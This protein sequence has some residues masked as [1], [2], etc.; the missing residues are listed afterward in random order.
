MF[1]SNCSI[2][3]SAFKFLFLTNIVNNF[4]VYF[5]FVHVLLGKKIRKLR[6]K[7]KLVLRQVAAQLEIDTP[8][9]SKIERG[10]RPAKEEYISIL[11]DLYEVEQEEL[12]KLWLADQIY[13]VVQEQDLALEAL[14]MVKEEIITDRE[15]SDQANN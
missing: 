6:K 7:K 3:K 4:F 12:H 11:A 14:K 9:M 5:L 10:D 15:Q 13:E 2:N 1:D 8:T